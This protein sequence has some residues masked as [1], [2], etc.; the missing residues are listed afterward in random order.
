MVFTIHESYPG[1][2]FITTL[3]SLHRL[4][5]LMP[6]LLNHIR[7][8]SPELGAILD[9]KSP[10][11]IPAGW[12]LETKFFSATASFGTLYNHFAWTTKKT[13]PL[14]CWEGVFTAPLLSSRRSIV[15]RVGSHGNVFTESLPSNGYAY[16]N[17]NFPSLCEE[18]DVGRTSE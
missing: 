8:P 12:R 6:F 14:Y 4:F 9:N 2:G 15:T 16:Y 17:T 1:N 7:L 18:T 13:Q 5:F 11:H 3:L 10:A